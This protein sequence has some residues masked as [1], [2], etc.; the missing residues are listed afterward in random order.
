MLLKKLVKNIK[1][2]FNS[3]KLFLKSKVI[4][5]LFFEFLNF[6]NKIN[7]LKTPYK[8][9]DNYF[10][11]F[12]TKNFI[13]IN[14]FENKFED[15]VGSFGHDLEVTKRHFNFIVNPLWERIF[16]INVEFFVSAFITKYNFNFFLA[17][18]NRYYL[19]ICIFYFI[20]ISFYTDI[21]V[22]RHDSFDLSGVKV[23]TR[24]YMYLV[25]KKSNLSNLKNIHYIISPYSIFF[26]F[27]YLK[28][29]YL[30]FEFTTVPFY[31]LEE[32][33]VIQLESWIIFFRILL[34]KHYSDQKIQTAYNKRTW[35]LDYFY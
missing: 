28:L 33:F 10:N 9:F 15:K 24:D 12:L 27:D 32:Y 4:N 5:N 6:I 34:I 25:Y 18:I 16:E 31:Y 3:F 35:V 2:Y 22:L 29:I 30:T 11:N 8:Y 20:Q 19:D 14:K 17:I 23:L 13:K 26:D 7:Y 21:I 1:I